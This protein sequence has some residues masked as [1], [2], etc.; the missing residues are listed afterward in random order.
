[1]NQ[2]TLRVMIPRNARLLIRRVSGIVTPKAEEGL[3]MQRIFKVR[4]RLKRESSRSKTWI[5]WG[6]F[7]S[8]VLSLTCCLVI[9]RL[10]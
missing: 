4:S 1:M 10:V 7:D 2:P 3:T 8:G 6:T 5:D 9:I